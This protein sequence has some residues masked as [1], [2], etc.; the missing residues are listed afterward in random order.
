MSIQSYFSIYICILSILIFAI[1]RWTDIVTDIGCVNPDFL[2]IRR[3][4]KGMQRRKTKK[5]GGN[6]H[7][8]LS[9]TKCKF[10]TIK[11]YRTQIPVLGGRAGAKD[12]ARVKVTAEKEGNLNIPLNV[13]SGEGGVLMAE[14]DPQENQELSPAEKQD[15]DKLPMGKEDFEEEEDTQDLDTEN[16]SSENNS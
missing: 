11:T 4:E 5:I 8:I 6:L 9:F 14:L 16:E 1:V 3:L 15:T 2:D 13:D 7:C 10:Q 12:A